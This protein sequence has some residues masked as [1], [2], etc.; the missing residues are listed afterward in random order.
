MRSADEGIPFGVCREPAAEE[1]PSPAGARTGDEETGMRLAMGGNRGAATLF[2]T[3]DPARTREASTEG[4]VIIIVV[5]Q[6]VT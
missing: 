3:R 1:V 4:V 2:A 6:N 5:I